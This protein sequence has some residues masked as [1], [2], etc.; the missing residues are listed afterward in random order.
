MKTV[1]LPAAFGVLLVTLGAL[2]ESAPS[3]WESAK[4][5]AAREGWQLHVMVRELIDVEAEDVGRGLRAAGLERARD[6]LESAG[7]EHGADLRLRFDLGDVYERLGRHSDAI[8]VLEP[9]V[10]VQD[11]SATGLP[12]ALLTLSYAYAKLGRPE[13][14][15]R[16]YRRIL[17]LVQEQ[18]GRATA[19]LNL[20]EAE[21]HQGNLE[22]AIDLYEESERAASLSP[23]LR[24]SHETTALAVWGLAVATDRSG[25]AAKAMMQKKRA[26]GLDPG[27]TILGNPTRVFFEPSY[28]RLWYI[29]AGLEAELDDTDELKMRAVY[30]ARL[31]RVW[32]TYVNVA[33]KTDRW[34]ALAK[35]R[36]ARAKVRAES[37]WIRAGRPRLPADLP[38]EY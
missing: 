5:P 2:A 12:D 20:A 31:V 10:N 33:R 18:R 25:D 21:M 16:T 38:V 6:A 3:V 8:R 26:L 24:S 1:A 14:E 19:L 13:E 37:E 23:L 15:A 36:Q 35:Q 27:G 17:G 7:V 11:P 28:E 22:Q 9:A 4:N 32:T 29:A 30:A 34:L